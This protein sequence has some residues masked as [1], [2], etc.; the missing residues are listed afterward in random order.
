[1]KG[2]YFITTAHKSHRNVKRWRLLNWQFYAILL[3]S[4]S[5][6]LL[7]CV[8]SVH[9]LL[10]Q[11]YAQNL[12]NSRW[13]TTLFS[14]LFECTIIIFRAFKYASFVLLCILM[15]SLLTTLTVCIKLYCG[16]FCDLCLCV[17]CATSII[18]VQINENAV[19]D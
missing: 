4:L 6:S 2:Y 10:Q 14:L 16:R 9:E 1:M 13:H 12:L 3:S 19:K 7:V 5:P 11:A 15:W 18:S 8:L 17:C